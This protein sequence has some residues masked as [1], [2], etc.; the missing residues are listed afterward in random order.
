MALAWSEVGRG[1]PVVGGAPMHVLVSRHRD[2]RL[3]GDVGARFGLTTVHASSSRGGGVGLL[4]L[5]RL[6]G[7]GAH[8]AITPDGPRGPRRQA[9]PGVAGLAALTG[10]PVLPCAAATSRRRLLGS[11]DRMVLPLPFGRGVI[12]VQPPIV[13]PRR[14]G[15]GA[16]PAIQ[17]ALTEACDRADALAAAGAAGAAAGPPPRSGPPPHESGA[18]GAGR[19]GPRMTARGCAP[20]SAPLTA[21]A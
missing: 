19:D 13:V 18:P 2:G 16:L 21:R 9:A 8:V 11:W 12:V 14:G 20:A 6:L 17:A 10:R 1:L 4:S 15:E 5:A 3:I 7:Q